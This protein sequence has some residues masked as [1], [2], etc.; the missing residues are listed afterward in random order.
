VAPAR[1]GGQPRASKPN[2]RA[3]VPQDT[4]WTPLERPADP[5][6]KPNAAEGCAQSVP[7]GVLGRRVAFFSHVSRQGLREGPGGVAILRPGLNEPAEVLG[8][9]VARPSDVELTGRST[10]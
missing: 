1:G 10:G 6:F 5:V 7:L 4:F 9:V 2:P 8:R 3:R